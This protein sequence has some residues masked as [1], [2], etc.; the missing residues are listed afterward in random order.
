MA[1]S[2]K[3]K[4]LREPAPTVVVKG[5]RRQPGDLDK[6]SVK[7]T[8]ALDPYSVVFNYYA[9]PGSDPKTWTSSAEPTINYSLSIVG[10]KDDRKIKVST[11]KI[12]CDIQGQKVEAAADAGDWVLAPTYENSFVLPGFETANKTATIVCQSLVQLA[13]EQDAGNGQYIRRSVTDTLKLTLL[14][15]KIGD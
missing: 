7:H 8:L 13:I 11:V 1:D 2:D 9:A 12:V 5:V 3:V 10:L 15:T 4:Q 14:P 6:G